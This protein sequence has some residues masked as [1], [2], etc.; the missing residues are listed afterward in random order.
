[1]FFIDVDEIDV[2][3]SFVKVIIFE[4][5][6]VNG[7]GTHEELQQSHLYYQQLLSSTALS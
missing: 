4:D 7:S 3:D 2:S 1:M 6:K 5:G